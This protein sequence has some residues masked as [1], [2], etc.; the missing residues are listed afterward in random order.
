MSK[1]E[2]LPLTIDAAVYPAESMFLVQHAASAE[3]PD[4]RSI[5]IG[6]HIGEPGIIVQGLG[7][8][9]VLGARELITAILKYEEQ[10]AAEVPT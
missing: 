3:L 5:L 8:S 1:K 6:Y 7:Q 4:K 2:T 10:K 9:Y